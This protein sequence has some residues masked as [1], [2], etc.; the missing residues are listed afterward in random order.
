M[1]FGFSGTFSVVYAI[2]KVARMAGGRN[3]VERLGPVV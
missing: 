1:R 3:R 2:A